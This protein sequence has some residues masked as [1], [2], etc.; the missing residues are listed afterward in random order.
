M[1]VGGIAGTISGA[2]TLKNVHVNASIVGLCNVGA[3]AGK[4][5]TSNQTVTFT[6]MDIHAKLSAMGRQLDEVDIGGLAGLITAG[7]KVVLNTSQ[8][9]SFGN[10][11]GLY[12]SKTSLTERNK[13]LENDI[14]AAENRI[15]AL[16][17]ENEVL[18]QEITDGNYADGRNEE[19]NT[20]QIAANEG[21]IARLNDRIAQSNTQLENCKT[22][23]RGVETEI[24]A[25][26]EQLK[27]SLGAS[28]LNDKSNSEVN[29][30]ILNYYKTLNDR[31]N[32]LTAEQEDLTAQLQGEPDDREALQEQLDT[33]SENLADASFKLLCWKESLR[34]LDAT[35]IK[36]E[37]DEVDLDGLT[38]V[39]K[40]GNNKVI[41]F[42]G[43][44]STGKNIF[45]VEI[46]TMLYTYSTQVNLNVG[47]VIGN[48]GAL[49]NTSVLDTYSY[50]TGRSVVTDVGITNYTEQTSTAVVTQNET[51]GTLY[52][53]NPTVVL[54][55]SVNFT[56]ITPT[57][58]PHTR[59]Y[60]YCNFTSV[61]YLDNTVSSA[62]QLCG[63]NL[64]GEYCL[65]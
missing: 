46:N 6:D 8:S 57:Q 17:S 5:E 13:E 42:I 25:F 47:A 14:A 18:Q 37:D 2:A 43:Q 28:I 60:T 62:K 55:G 3:V 30:Y 7:S 26:D 58:R 34:E 41:A 32:S 22:E 31:V 52:L 40:E 23:L 54:G 38:S 45:D 11:Q 64:Y 53:N 21:I 48:N 10:L 39:L 4:I 36:E 20:A 15:K 49:N 1:N 51:D 35:L 29:V 59:C 63:L 27:Q 12:S 56:S 9:D 24:R 65:R 61:V 50:L 16:E 44:L 19:T 33:V